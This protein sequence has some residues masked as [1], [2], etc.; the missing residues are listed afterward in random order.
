MRS[1]SFPQNL[2][3]DRYDNIIILAGEGPNTESIDSETI[4]T[5]LRI[6]TLFKEI[7][8]EKNAP[9][10]TQLITELMDSANSGIIQDMGEKD[11]LISDQFVSKIMAHISEEPDVKR[12]YDE[13]FGEKGSEIYMKSAGLYL[14]E[15]P[16]TTTFTDLMFAAQQRYEVAFG[17]KFKEG[18][19]DPNSKHGLQLLPDKDELFLITEEDQLIVLAEDE[20]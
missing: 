2:H 20:T 17:I 13:L 18:T 4:S 16:T 12:V 3:P 10:E 6:R 14:E 7:E 1:S 19:V 9:A 15:L 11:F 8:R 5:L